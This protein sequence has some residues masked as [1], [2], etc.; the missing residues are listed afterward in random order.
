MASEQNKAFFN[1]EAASYD[2]KHERT[3]NQIVKEIQSRLDFIG[4]D[5]VNDDDDSDNDGT[6]DKA[7]EGGPTKQVRLL[8]Y[9]SGT[10]S[11]KYPL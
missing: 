10:G 7:D 6:T 9:A 5:W 11:S 4:V 8:D 3:L 2:A 1:Q